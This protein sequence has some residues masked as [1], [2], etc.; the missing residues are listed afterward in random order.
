M[1]EDFRKCSTYSKV[2]TMLV[3]VYN[4]TCFN[5]Q[6]TVSQFQ[7]SQ[8]QSAGA[9]KKQTTQLNKFEVQQARN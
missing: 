7:T 5:F 8:G 9:K 4:T 1:Y 2:S 6:R 3:N